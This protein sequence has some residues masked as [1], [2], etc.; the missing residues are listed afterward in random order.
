MYYRRANQ[1]RYMTMTTKTKTDLDTLFNEAMW[2][3]EGRKDAE[4]LDINSMLFGIS[5]RNAY[6]KW[7]SNPKRAKWMG[8]SAFFNDY[9]SHLAAA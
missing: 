1:K 8:L 6:K 4:N 9:T 3:A 2:Y 5:Y 7:E